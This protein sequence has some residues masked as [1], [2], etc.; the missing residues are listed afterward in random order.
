MDDVSLPAWLEIL[1]ALGLGFGPLLVFSSAVI[2]AYIAWRTYRQRERADELA[3]RQRKEADERSEWW[4]RTQWAVD[5]ATD[6]DEERAI[7]GLEALTLLAASPLAA[8]EDRDLLET[9]FEEIVAARAART[10]NG[11]TASDA[12]TKR[13]GWK[14]RRAR[15]G[16]RAP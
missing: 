14:F 9:L 1:R 6:A 12:E 15:R 13:P 10:Y 5:H 8:E 11:N 3:Y 16:E 2:A 7:I 4:R